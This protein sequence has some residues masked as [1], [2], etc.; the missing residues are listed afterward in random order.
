MMPFG[1]EGNR[2][3]VVALAMRH[4]LR[5]FI[6]IRAQ[7]L[8]RGRWALRL[9]L[10]SLRTMAPLTFIHSNGHAIMFYSCDLLFIFFTHKSSRPKNAA[11]TGPLHADQITTFW[12]AKICKFFP[13]VRGFFADFG[14]F[15]PYKFGIAQDRPMATMKQR[16]E[17]TYFT[18]CFCK[19]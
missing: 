1:W 18:E 3:C 2:R 19:I 7:W 6:H 9:R 10:N 12:G 13:T 14:A 4:G 8:T 15:K 11:P 16:S 17:T 5:W